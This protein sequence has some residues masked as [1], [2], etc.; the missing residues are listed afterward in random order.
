MV[1]KTFLSS[2]DPITFWE[3]L[4]KGKL[5]FSW[6]KKTPL[7]QYLDLKM[8][9]KFGSDTTKWDYRK[10]IECI[11]DIIKDVTDRIGESSDSE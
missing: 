3:K 6:D 2:R 4:T 1:I 9:E 5:G 8:I 11:P 10:A 7:M